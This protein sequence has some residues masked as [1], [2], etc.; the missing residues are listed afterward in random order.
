M[1]TFSA[2]PK[3]VKR[4]WYLVDA[5]D[6]VLGRLAAEV[7]HR[8]RGKHKP[9][10]TPHVDTGDYIVV[11]NAEKVAV[12]GNKANAKV[13]HRHTGYP[14]GIKSIV[15]KDMLERHPARVIEMAVK[16]MLPKNKLGRAM[17]AKLR[18]YAGG[19]HA[20]AAQQP[21]PLEI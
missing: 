7:A 9:E 8:L 18:V 15:Y 14:G 10:Y 5:T 2:K 20:H 21:K 11:I 13:Y 3:E 4:D 19:E 17:F 1:K 6:K 16:G 12:T